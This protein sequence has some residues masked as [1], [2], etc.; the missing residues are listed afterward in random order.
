MR[1]DGRRPV[2]E[3]VADQGPQIQQAGMTSQRVEGALV[4]VG[5]L[6]HHFDQFATMH[7]GADDL[8]TAFPHPIAVPGRQST[9]HRRPRRGSEL[10]MVE[11]LS[12]QTFQKA[13]PGA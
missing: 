10:C 12:E 9:L 11:E 5:S 7:Q 8:T 3:A 2:I 13:L 6:N 1:R 4:T